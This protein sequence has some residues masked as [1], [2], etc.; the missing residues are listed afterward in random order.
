MQ[1]EGIP[2]CTPIDRGSG[3]S[4]VHAEM[5]AQGDGL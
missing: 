2:H 1:S 5:P 4:P 3:R